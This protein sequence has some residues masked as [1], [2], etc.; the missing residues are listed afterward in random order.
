MNVTTLLAIAVITVGSRVAALALLPPPKGAAAGLVRRLP[1]PLFAA[2]AALSMTSSDG[3][4]A[5]PAMLAAV[6]CALL[7]TRWSSLL[8]TLGAGLA[9]FL[10]ASLIW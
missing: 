4:V 2:L 3:G 9:G 8:I 5:D 6:C 10:V 7:A 1:A